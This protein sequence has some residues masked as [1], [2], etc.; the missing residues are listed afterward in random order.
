MI[1]NLILMTALLLLA[2]CGGSGGSTSSSGGT[3]PGVPP[4]IVL[5][6]PETLQHEQGSSYLDP[7]ANATDES[8]TS[9]LVVTTHQVDVEKA[10]TYSVSYTATDSAGR[11]GTASRSVNVRD[12]TKPVITLIG[13]ETLYLG[14]GVLYVDSGA[15]AVDSVDGP[16]A[17]DILEQV[18]TS[19]S[20]TYTVTYRAT[21]AAENTSSI[22]RRVIVNSIM[23]G[24]WE[25]ADKTRMLTISSE[26]MVSRIGRTGQAYSEICHGALMLK[27]DM[28]EGL[29]SCLTYIDSVNVSADYTEYAI[30]GT[31]VSNSRVTFSKFEGFGNSAGQRVQ[32]P[33]YTF[34]LDNGPNYSGDLVAGLYINELG[35]SNA[36]A[37][38]LVSFVRVDKNGLLTPVSPAQLRPNDPNEWLGVSPFCQLSGQILA[39]VGATLEGANQT[40]HF[41]ATVSMSD[42]N[43]TEVPTLNSLSNGARLKG[44]HVQTSTSAFGSTGYS[45][46]YQDYFF[47][48]YTPGNG[49]KNPGWDRYYRVCDDSVVAQRTAYGVAIEQQYTAGNL[50]PAGFNNLCNDFSAP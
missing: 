45:P 13:N 31:V 17:V 5:S 22:D 43:T 39:P 11:E 41:S 47:D 25:S 2:G 21:D 46:T 6:G 44:D 18:D 36:N 24:Y 33:D 40:T 19:V 9:L 1:K 20:G 14:Y 3:A 35:N 4:T 32:E 37:E 49:G 16:L 12:T 42:C 7:G 15:N 8:G 50:P 27:G 30:A 34:G 23:S 26:G 38:R 10:G 48:L 29:L 28:F